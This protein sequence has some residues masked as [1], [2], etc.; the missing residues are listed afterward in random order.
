[1]LFYNDTLFTGNYN[2]SELHECLEDHD[3]QG[4]CLFALGYSYLQH[5]EKTRESFSGVFLKISHANPGL[6][7]R[8][9]ALL[10]DMDKLEYD[11]NAES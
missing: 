9:W 3:S 4:T 10:I 1:M 2:F 7:Y 6:G 5:S 8:P 11:I